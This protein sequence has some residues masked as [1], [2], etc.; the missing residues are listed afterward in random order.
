[1][2]DKGCWGE[3]HEHGTT[4]IASRS[5]TRESASPTASSDVCV[6]ALRGGLP[7]SKAATTCAKGGKPNAH[8]AKPA[9]FDVLIIKVH[10]S[11]E[12]LW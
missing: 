8:S 11:S 2:I 10:S 4:A 1:M 12:T 3:H 5:E 9:R 6:E 7:R